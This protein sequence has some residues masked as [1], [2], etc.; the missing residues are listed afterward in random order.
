[1]C[2]RSFRRRN[3]SCVLNL[4]SAPKVKSRNN[5]RKVPGRADAFHFFFAD[6]YKIAPVA[7]RSPRATRADRRLRPSARPARQPSRRLAPILQGRSS[8]AGDARWR[9]ALAGRALGRPGVAPRTS[10]R[11]L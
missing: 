1:M 8:F 10:R 3:D 11:V 6:R 7:T 5:K 2:I 4:M 9:Y